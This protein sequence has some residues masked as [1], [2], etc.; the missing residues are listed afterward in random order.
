M[1]RA[2][3]FACLALIGGACTSA[4]APAGDEGGGLE[5][6]YR[7]LVVEAVRPADWQEQHKVSIRWKDKDVPLP[8]VFRVAG[9]AEDF[10]LGS[11]GEISGHLQ[12]GSAK[13]PVTAA[14]E[15]KFRVRN[16]GA[17]GILPEQASRK[18]RVGLSLAGSVFVSPPDFPG[19]VGP[20][21][22]AGEALSAGKRLAKRVRELVEAGHVIDITPEK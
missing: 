10:E 6:K 19:E 4:P 11:A 18:D 13:V 2:T 21:P 8:V 1:K 3:T 14:P 5:V 7:Y 12:I 15:A 22:K 9:P 16:T 20:D 17:I